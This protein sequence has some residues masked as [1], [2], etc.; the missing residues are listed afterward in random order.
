MPSITSIVNATFSFAQFPIAWKTAEVTPILKDGD[1]EVP[2]NNRPISLLPVVSKICERAAHDQLTSYLTANQR[3]TPKQC[4]N[5]KWNSTETSLIQTTDTILEAMD[6]KQLTVT[7]L[8][9]M[10]KTFD[11][12]D[13]EILNTKLQDVGLSPSAIN[14]FHSYLQ[15]RYQVV[16][17]QNIISDRLP[18]TCGVPQGSILGP[19]QFSIYTNELP[20]DSRAQLHSVLCRRY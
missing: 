15:A 19:L 5:K 8:L 13:H 6:K 11:S 20:S 4:G 1:H 2:N 7:V 3:L 14:W 17:I 18:V 16:K 10:S 12:I 9:D